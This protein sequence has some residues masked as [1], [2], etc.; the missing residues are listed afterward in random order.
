MSDALLVGNDT[1]WKGSDVVEPALDSDVVG[2][3]DGVEGDGVGMVSDVRS[4]ISM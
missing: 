4:G 3:V 1:S 2:V